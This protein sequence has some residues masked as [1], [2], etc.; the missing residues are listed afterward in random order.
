MFQ[1]GIQCGITQAA[2]IYAKASNKY[3]VDQHNLH[4]TS[5]YPNYLQGNS[6]YECTMIQK[7]ANT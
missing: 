2:K 3:M 5:K 4:N 7:N 6:L 1:K